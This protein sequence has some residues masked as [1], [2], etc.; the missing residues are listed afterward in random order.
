MAKNAT[1]DPYPIVTFLKC[2]YSPFYIYIYIYILNGY[3]S[4][5]KGHYSQKPPK[6]NMITKMDFRLICVCVEVNI[7]G[8]FMEFAGLLMEF[9]NEEMG[10]RRKLDR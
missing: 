4:I 10:E 5:S 2:D 3:S 7:F 1:I 8:L 6:K 9:S